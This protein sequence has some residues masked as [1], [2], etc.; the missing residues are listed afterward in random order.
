M[1]LRGPEGPLFHG[2]ANDICWVIRNNSHALSKAHVDF[3]RLPASYADEQGNALPWVQRVDSIGVNGVHAIVVAPV[4][5]R[6]QMPQRIN[7][8]LGRLDIFWKAL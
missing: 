3:G 4:L 2:T 6:L 1:A 7:V 5:I 8:L